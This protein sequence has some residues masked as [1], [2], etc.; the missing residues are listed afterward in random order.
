MTVFPTIRHS[1]SHFAVDL[2]GY[3][4]N[5]CLSW[6]AARN[7]APH[8]AI[9]DHISPWKKDIFLPLIADNLTVIPLRHPYLTAKSWDD[10]KKDR[11]DLIDS[12]LVLVEDI[13]P[14]QPFYLPLD[15][16]DRQDY[17]DTLN[18][19]TGR[20]MAT[21]WSPQGVVHNNQDLRH[22]DL[23]PSADILALCDRIGGFLSRFYKVPPT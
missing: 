15:V 19:A 1:G 8:D 3:D 22:T 6:K 10:R 11:Q 2:M 7:A 12:W 17:L 14:L 4:V 13:D 5:R 21:D 16:P 20:D 18:A 9:F 23:T